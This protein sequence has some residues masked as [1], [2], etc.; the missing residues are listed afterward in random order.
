MILKLL[1]YLVSVTETLS[2]VPC[3]VVLVMVKCRPEIALLVILSPGVRRPTTHCYCYHYYCHS[4]SREWLWKE[5]AGWLECYSCHTMS[6]QSGMDG[7]MLSVH[8]RMP[9][10]AGAADWSI[11]VVL[12]RSKKNGANF[13]KKKETERKRK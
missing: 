13:Q 4:C 6:S 2:V 12:K 5:R 7:L 11:F 3:A 9:H 1:C 8:R 10:G